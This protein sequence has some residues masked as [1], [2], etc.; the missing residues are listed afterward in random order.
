M[1]Q[2]ARSKLKAGKEL[3]TERDQ[4]APMLRLNLATDPRFDSRHFRFP[5]CLHQ[6]SDTLTDIHCTVVMGR[7]P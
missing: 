6:W 1:G 4:L 5:D 3:V 7:D 2:N